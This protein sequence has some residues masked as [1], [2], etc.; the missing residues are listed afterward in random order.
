V[1]SLIHNIRENPLRGFYYGTLRYASDSP[2]FVVLGINLE[3]RHGFGYIAK[4]FRDMFWSENRRAY[5]IAFVAL[6]G[7][8]GEKLVRARR[9]TLAH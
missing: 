7:M 8:I 9:E 3:S 5:S 2:F 6:A 4:M 1:Y